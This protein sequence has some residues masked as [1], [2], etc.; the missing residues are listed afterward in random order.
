MFQVYRSPV[1]YGRYH[2]PREP[3]ALLLVQP[4]PCDLRCDQGVKR[5]GL[6]YAASPLFKGAGAT[7]TW[8]DAASALHDVIALNAYSLDGSYADLFGSNNANSSELIFYRRYGN[9][10]N[11]EKD[12]FPIVFQNSDGN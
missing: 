1:R 4:G 2:H 3:G 8:A 7:A 5:E 10:N 12:N 11:V 6:V 9:T